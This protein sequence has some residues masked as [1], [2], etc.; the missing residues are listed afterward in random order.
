MYPNKHQFIRLPGLYKDQNAGYS[1]CLNTNVT[2]NTF[3]LIKERFEG[4]ANDASFVLD[5][6][7]RYHTNTNTSAKKEPKK[8]VTEHD[9][10]CLSVAN[11]FDKYFEDIFKFVC[12]GK[13][14]KIIE[15]EIDKPFCCPF[16][17]DNSP[18]AKISCH[19]L[20]GETK[21]TF[22][23]FSHNC[24]MNKYRN[25]NPL[26]AFS[27]LWYFR[28]GEEEMSQKKLKALF[29]YLE[30]R[31][32]SLYFSKYIWD[33]KIN[34][35]TFGHDITKYIHEN[36][37]RDLE[38]TEN[39]IIYMYDS[40]K[41]IWVKSNDMQQENAIVR[42]IVEDTI[43]KKYGNIGLQILGFKNFE[44]IATV[45]KRKILSDTSYFDPNF[46]EDLVVPLKKGKCLD[47]SPVLEGGT[48]EI[49]DMEKNDKFT[50]RIN[51]TYD[52]N[53][54]ESLFLDALREY[55]PN[56]QDFNTFCEFI[57]TCLFP[58]IRVPNFLC[59]YGEGGNGKGTCMS[60]L[61]NFFGVENISGV[62]LN[63]LGEKFSMGRMVGK[64]VNI[65]ADTT[66]GMLKQIDIKGLKNITGHD[67]MQVE[68]KFKNPHD[69]HILA[70]M[71]FASNTQMQ[72]GVNDAIMRRFLQLYFGVK[73][74]RSQEKLGYSLK[75]ISEDSKTGFLN[76][77][78]IALKNFYDRGQKFIRSE[79]SIQILEQQK[80]ME[81][82]VYA[83]ITSLF[84][85]EYNDPSKF[86]TSVYDARLTNI[87]LEKGITAA[88]LYRDF[89]FFVK[90][91]GFSKQKNIETIN[92]ICFGKKIAKIINQN[93]LPKK[94]ASC[95]E[96]YKSGGSMKYKIF[97]NKFLQISEKE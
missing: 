83:F 54:T 15:F 89:G 44:E 49:R 14:T 46:K 18:S 88:Q 27:L 85:E 7:E 79:E 21:K 59:L 86:P 64:L 1:V 69:A 57:A 81:C 66:G 51:V 63:Q 82:P 32:S 4:N 17:D 93:S 5:I 80:R 50:Y 47:F 6:C 60:F 94:M 97:V 77:C 84:E 62:A 30:Q 23:C 31:L 96:K 26:D 35:L 41:K 16:H 39:G 87:E 3:E 10:K 75:L 52:P 2:L 8:F 43:N 67:I 13:A 53:V 68:S 91:A 58:S 19:P 74:S 34:T 9:P 42:C 61:S 71:I 55:L 90:E 11:Q 22:M 76:Y 38:S 56:E 36:P 45:A 33:K 40:N 24:E 73:I 92:S 28:Y 12:Y 20:Y 25:G 37:E 29:Q 65:D 70:K 95:I 78:L 48:V 72:L